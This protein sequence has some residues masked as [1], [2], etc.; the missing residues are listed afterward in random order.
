MS[1]IYCFLVF[2]LILFIISPR[3]R[4]KCKIGQ[5]EYGIGV[6]FTKQEAKQLA[7]KLAYEKIES[8]TMVCTALGF[9]FYILKFSLKLI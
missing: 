1:Y 5:K 8:E 9:D 6:G 3:F 7:A 4:Y 2:D